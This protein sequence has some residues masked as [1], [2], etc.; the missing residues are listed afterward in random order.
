M[1][2]VIWTHFPNGNCQRP[3]EFGKLL[4]AFSILKISVILSFKYLDKAT[5]KYSLRS[6]CKQ[7]RWTTSGRFHR[8]RGIC[9]LLTGTLVTVVIY[10]LRRVVLSG[11]RTIFQ[12]FT[13]PGQTVI[14]TCAG[15]LCYCK[16]SECWYW[17]IIALLDAR[18]TPSVSKSLGIVEVFT[19]Q[20]LNGDSDIVGKSDVQAAEKGLRP[21]FDDM[22][23]NRE[24]LWNDPCRMCPTQSTYAQVM[25]FISNVFKGSFGCMR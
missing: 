7:T 3:F 15:K 14:D 25:H 23:L 24:K 12:K 11:W 2:M 6:H 22:G 9:L 17:G 10:A 8:R 21:A 19:W 13:P 16:R 4:L 20:I 5:Q 1:N 18:L